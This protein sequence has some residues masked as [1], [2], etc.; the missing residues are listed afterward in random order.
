MA[1][2]GTKGAEADTFCCEKGWWRFCRGQN[3]QS[4][5]PWLRATGAH[6]SFW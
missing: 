2:R 3:P 5:L 1:A 6:L 4:G